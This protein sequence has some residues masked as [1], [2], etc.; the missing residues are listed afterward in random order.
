MKLINS[1]SY[2]CVS[3]YIILFI[4]NLTSAFPIITCFTIIYSGWFIIIVTLCFFMYGRMF[5]SNIYFH[6]MYLY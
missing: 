3:R 6:C 5:M 2:I 4:I 1:Y